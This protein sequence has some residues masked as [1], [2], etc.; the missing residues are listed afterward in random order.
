MKINRNNYEIFFIDFYDGKLTNAQKLELDLFLE[1]HPI[2]KLE[3]EEFENIKLDTSEITFSS[4]QTLK[5]PEIVAFNGI[6]EENYEET[7]IAF[8]ENDLQADEKASLLSFLKANPHVEKEFQSHAS[9]LLKKEDIV[10]EDKDSLKK[11][12]YIGYY[13]YGAAAAILI[14][15]ALGFFLIQNRPTP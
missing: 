12:T 1:D 15:L 8:Y 2:L 9:L 7:F 13:W 10:F 4:K 5:K 11:K 3:F 14:F 6:D